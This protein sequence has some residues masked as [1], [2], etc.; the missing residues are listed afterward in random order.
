MV[1]ARVA[2]CCT[3]TCWSWNELH[4]REGPGKSDTK[5]RVPS[6][7]REDDVQVE[8]DAIAELLGVGT[9]FEPGIQKTHL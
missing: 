7:Q 4:A 9:P 1:S 6:S 2:Q 5:L 3:L 8:L